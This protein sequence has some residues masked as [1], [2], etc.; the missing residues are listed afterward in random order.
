MFNS[1]P[2]LPR[3]TSLCVIPLNVP[4]FRL[5]LITPPRRGGVLNWLRPDMQPS[6]RPFPSSFLR[7]STACGPGCPPN[8]TLLVFRTR[9]VAS[10][11]ENRPPLLS[12]YSIPGGWNQLTFRNVPHWG[13]T[14]APVTRSAVTA[15]HRSRCVAASER[16]VWRWRPWKSPTFRRHCAKSCV[17]VCRSIRAPKACLWTRGS[18]EDGRQR[19]SPD[20]PWKLVSVSKYCSVTRRSFHFKIVI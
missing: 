9:K 13:Q 14:G 10:R 11:L 16:R 19:K 15:R 2:A 1:P 3:L 20:F 5:V 8:V 17:L 12:G 18:F 4:C 7:R 6:R